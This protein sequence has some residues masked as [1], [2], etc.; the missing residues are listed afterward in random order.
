MQIY[1]QFLKEVAFCKK[2][3][4]TL[5][6]TSENNISNYLLAIQWRKSSFTVKTKTFLTCFIQTSLAVN[7]IGLHLLTPL[8][9]VNFLHS[10]LCG[11][12]VQRQNS[13]VIVFLQVNNFLVIPENLSSPIKYLQDIL[14]IVD[15]VMFNN[16]PMYRCNRKV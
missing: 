11:W 2:S 10:S 8:C 14:K 13:G 4:Q 3:T 15:I 16:P 5:H 9:L 12:F 6:K 1:F 7:I